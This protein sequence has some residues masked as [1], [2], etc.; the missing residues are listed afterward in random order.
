MYRYKQKF[1]DVKLNIIYKDIK[2]K[3]IKIRN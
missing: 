3:Y 2:I 1:I